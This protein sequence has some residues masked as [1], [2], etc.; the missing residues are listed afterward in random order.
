MLNRLCLLLLALSLPNY[1]LAA[2]PLSVP[3]PVAQELPVELIESQQEIA[4]SVP[5]T[6]NA[7]GMQFGLIGALVGSAIQNSQ[8]K[9]AE[10]RVVPLRNLLVDYRFNQKMQESLQA[11]LVADGIS[12]HPLLTVLPTVWEAHDAQQTAKLPPYALVLTPGYAVDNEFAQ[13]T[14]SLRAQVVDRIVKSNGKIK[15]VPRFNRLYAFQFPLQGARSADPVQDWVAL[16]SAGMAQL[17]DQGIA[18]T[19]DMLVQDFSAEGRAVWETKAKGQSVTVGGNVYEG[20]PV[21]QGEGWAWVRNGKGWMQNVQGYQPLT[22]GVQLAIQVPA[23]AT[24]TVAT[25]AAPAT[26]ATTATVP[27]QTQTAVAVRNPGA[28]GAKTAEAESAPAPS[29]TTA[30]PAVT[31]PEEAPAATQTE[32]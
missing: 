27:V 9:K 16:G 3:M 19:T 4:V 6:A 8:A 15:V 11:K 17:L 29:S 2:K 18:Q 28:I 21:R 23:T 10:E 5:D 30:E 31:A 26:T 25:A 20:M 13:L 7:V 32:G 14:V 1:C 22:V 12:P 24:A